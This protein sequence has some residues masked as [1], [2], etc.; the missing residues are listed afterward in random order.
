MRKEIHTWVPAL[1]GTILEVGKRR[2]DSNQNSPYPQSFGVDMLPGH[3]VD[4]VCDAVSL[5]FEDN[6]WDHVV[7]L[8]TLEHVEFWREVLTE[9]WRVCR[10]TMVITTPTRAKKFHGYPHDY[11]RWK[12]KQWFEVFRKQ[13]VLKSGKVWKKGIGIH[14][15]K[16][17][18]RLDLTVEPKR[19][20][21]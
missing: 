4:L 12:E 9:M 2:I 21:R 1:E 3:G 14:V 8:E 7:C 10:D 20:T 15:R 11:W 18:D 13:E 5:P 16:L 17:D 6:H 19:I